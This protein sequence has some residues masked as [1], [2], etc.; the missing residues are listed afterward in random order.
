MKRKVLV[1][2][3]TVIGLLVT[4]T[5]LDVAQLER[6]AAR[7][8]IPELQLAAGI[9]LGRLYADLKTI[10]EL[11]QL[12]V[13]GT[14]PGLRRAAQV[15][16]EILYIEAEESE[17]ELIAQAETGA[18]PELRAAVIPALVTVLAAR[19][20][21]ELRTLAI[22]GASHEIRL[23]A[24]RAYY[25]KRRA[26][27]ALDLEALQ[28][29]ATRNESRELEIA[30]G[31]LWGGYYLFHPRFIKTQQEL[32]QLANV[33]ESEGLRVAAGKA[34]TAMLIQGDIT[35]DELRL[36]LVANTGVKS[37]AFLNAYI[38]ALAARWVP[39]G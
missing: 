12:A 8:L 3:A 25:F 16:L 18:S 26:E 17:E 23:A 28:A 10:D 7:E 29:Q 1:L 27:L 14:T 2:V 15:A 33:A 13:D 11:E 30:A 39:P 37:P 32:G 35:A 34:L 9:A 4:G 31:E 6:W 22:E 19:E 21:E 36:V 20:V 5:A 38:Q 24:A